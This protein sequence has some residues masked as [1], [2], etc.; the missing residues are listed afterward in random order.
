MPEQFPFRLQR[1][2]SQRGLTRRTLAGT[3]GVSI[4]TLWAWEMGRTKP[5]PI[6]LLALAEALSV[7]STYLAAGKNGSK[8]ANGSASLTT[9]VA[10]VKEHIAALAGV[11]TDKVIISIEY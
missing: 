10:E 1:L 6:N 5:R 4:P 2:R 9:Y 3:I 7:S 8:P 11:Q